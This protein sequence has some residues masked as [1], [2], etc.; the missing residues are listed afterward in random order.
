MRDQLRSA[1]QPVKNALLLL[2]V[3]AISTIVFGQDNNSVANTQVTTGRLGSILIGV[4]GLASLIISLR[5]FRSSKKSAS[6][7]NRL[8]IIGA[9]SLGLLCVV[10]AA[11]H[12]VNSS[13]GFGT[14]SGKAGAIV[15]IVLG[16]A[17]IILS[18]LSLGRLRHAG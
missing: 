8:S 12:I 2:T 11:I 3:V 9:A 16:L 7:T 10:L 17:G 13:G 6:T 4:L 1:S 18:Y 5:N 15:A 14:G